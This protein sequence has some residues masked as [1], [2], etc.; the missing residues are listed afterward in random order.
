MCSLLRCRKLL[1]DDGVSGVSGAGL[2]DAGDVGVLSIPCWEAGLPTG[3][4]GLCRGC[5]PGVDIFANRA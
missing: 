2:D 5:E 4:Y 3:L 1:V